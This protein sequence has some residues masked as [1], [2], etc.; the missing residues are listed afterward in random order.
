[1]SRQQPI[2]QAT[3][4]EK[5]LDLQAC[6]EIIDIDDVNSEDAITLTDTEYGSKTT[7][8]LAV[9][10]RFHTEINSTLQQLHSNLP[11]LRDGINLL[12]GES[13]AGKTYSTIM[14]LIQCGFKEQVIHLDFDRNS[15]NK[16]KEIGVATYHINDTLA[17]LNAITA[18]GEKSINSLKSKIIVIDSLQDLSL[19][20]GVDS[21]SGA[22][23]TMKRIQG[24]KDTGATVIV[25]HHT[26]L[27][28]D[29]QQK[30]KG[31]ASVITSKADTTITFTKIDNQKRTMTILNSRA[32]DKIPSGTA[33]GITTQNNDF[34]IS[35]KSK[36]TKTARAINVPK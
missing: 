18:L 24:F 1:M 17:F 32:E 27:D 11:F 36:T 10:S 3:S 30:V 25:I 8:V 21:N 34:I 28:T 33:Y 22:L 6:E 20:D 29:K 23:R 16:L 9:F 2:T 14:S 7:E 5:K 35:L 13:K 4:L 26:T 31:N 19:E 12:I 15:D